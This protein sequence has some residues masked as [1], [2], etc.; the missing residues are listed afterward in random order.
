MEDIDSH[1]IYTYL[2]TC[3]PQ[4]KYIPIA[5]C[6]NP[7]QLN[8]SHKIGD[9]FAALHLYQSILSPYLGCWDLPSEVPKNLDYFGPSELAAGGTWGGYR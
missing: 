6:S 8:Y 9:M 5:G 2:D 3:L 7:L 1:S 4:K